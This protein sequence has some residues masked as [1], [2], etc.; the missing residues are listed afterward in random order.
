MLHGSELAAFEQEL[1]NDADLRAAVE[2]QRR[3]DR[4]LRGLMKATCPPAIAAREETSTAPQHDPPLH[5]AVSSTPHV[6][7]RMQKRPWLAR[8]AV[9]A[10]LVAGAYS[11][12]SIWLFVG[13]G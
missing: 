5:L 11:V 2:Q 1:Q 9:A 13:G 7:T 10:V 12:W 3:I 4:S 6:Q 8:L